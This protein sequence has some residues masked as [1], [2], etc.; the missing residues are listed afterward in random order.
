MNPQNPP[1][2][3]YKII[4]LARSPERREMMTAQ[5]RK[6]NIAD[7]ADFFPAVDGRELRGQPGWRARRGARAMCIAAAD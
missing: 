5:L 1:R 2:Y 7:K 3:R 6:L 4:N